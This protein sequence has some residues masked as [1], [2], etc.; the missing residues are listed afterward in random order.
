[1]IKGAYILLSR[2]GISLQKIFGIGK[3]KESTKNEGAD[4]LL[5]SSIKCD[6]INS[7]T[8]KTPGSHFLGTGV[9]G[10]KSHI[11]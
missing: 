4:L 3:L 1:M 11:G 7:S 9:V 6:M 2:I 5:L 8:R 10:E